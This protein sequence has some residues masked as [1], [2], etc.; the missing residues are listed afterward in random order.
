MKEYRIQDINADAVCGVSVQ[1]PCSQESYCEG[2]FK[3]TASSLLAQFASSQVSGGVLETWHHTPVFSELEYHE[4]DEMFYVMQG[5]AIMPFADMKDGQI[6]E[7]SIQIVRIPPGTQ[8]IISK[9]KAHMPPVAEEDAVS[10][11]VL[12]PRMEA[13]RV[14][15]KEEISG[16]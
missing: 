10:I 11:V 2:Y 13:P 6:V 1:M 3:W 8:F 12:S 4:D 7:D 16:I 14:G 15:L 5:T 9:G